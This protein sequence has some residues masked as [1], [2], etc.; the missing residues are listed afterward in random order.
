MDFVIQNDTNISRRMKSNG[1]DVHLNLV[2]YVL[3]MSCTLFVVNL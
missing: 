1:L 3:C 2:H